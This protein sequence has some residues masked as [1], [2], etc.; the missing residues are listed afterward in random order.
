VPSFRSEIV[1][2]VTSQRPGLQRLVLEGGDR[3]YVLTELVGEV[4]AGDEVVVNTTAVE[5]GLGTGGSHVVHLNL[6]RPHKGVPGP[7]HVMKARYLSEQLDAGSWEESATWGDAELPSLAGVRVVL[8]VLHSH[9]AALAVG[10]AAA[11][12][13][14]PGSVMTDQAALPLVR[15]DLVAELAANRLLA[16]TVS[17]GQSFGGD[18]EAV[19]VASGVEA[20][21]RRG[22][23]SVIVAAGPG[24]VGTASPIGF[25]ALELAG[26]ASVLSALGADVALAV[27]ASSADPRPRHNGVSHH[28]DTLLRLVPRPITVPL[29]SGQDPSWVEQL[30]HRA[31]SFPPFDLAAA[32]ADG[33]VEVSTMGRRLAD[34]ALALDYLGAAALWLRGDGAD[35]T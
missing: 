14:A 24:H 17:A 31:I 32:L 5:L 11:G 10:V 22:A 16:A 30:G 28:T 15:S 4:R 12:G 20:L 29:P 9:V 35:R 34:D 21:S 19:T 27:R 33:G 2:A 23:D 13:E 1:G 25:S 18:I 6:S 3:A 8:C 7:G 26:H